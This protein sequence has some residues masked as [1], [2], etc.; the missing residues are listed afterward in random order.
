MIDVRHDILKQGS[1]INMDR[2]AAY[3]KPQTVR[4]TECLRLW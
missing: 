2:D 4:R 1:R 3:Q